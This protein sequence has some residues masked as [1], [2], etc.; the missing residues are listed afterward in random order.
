MKSAVIMLYARKDLCFGIPKVP[1]QIYAMIQEHQR[2]KAEEEKRLKLEAEERRRE[3]ARKAMENR[4]SALEVE[5]AEL[6]SVQSRIETELQDTQTA[7]S[8]AAAAAAE[9]AELLACS[10][11]PPSAEVGAFTRKCSTE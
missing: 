6:L 2:T 5:K 8:T 9:L 4:I 10:M 7:A 3:E 11:C 1:S